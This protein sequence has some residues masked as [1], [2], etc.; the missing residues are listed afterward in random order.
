MFKL[1]II[2]ICKLNNTDKLIL[3]NKLSENFINMTIF[4]NIQKS[5]GMAVSRKPE[6][7]CYRNFHIADENTN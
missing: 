4:I 5:V 3:T 2:E 1:L 6:N 7:F